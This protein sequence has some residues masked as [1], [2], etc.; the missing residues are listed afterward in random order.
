MSARPLPFV[1]YESSR[2]V[3]NVVVD[4]APN[5][6]TV[7]A[8]THWPGV[9]QPAG[10]GDDLSAQM[11]FRYLDAPPEHPPAEV[12]TNNHFD[13][14]GLVSVHALV[15]PDLSLRHRE[16]LID[17]A[18]AG[19]FGTYRFRA[20]ARA[21]MAIW[22]YAHPERSPIADQL[23][24]LGYPDQCALLYET[25][26]PLLVEMATAPDRY[27]EL[28]NEEDDR[29][30]ASEK[31]IAS[32]RIRV[33]ERHDVDL[34]V[35]VIDEGLP[36]LGGHRFGHDALHELHPMAINNATSCLRLLLVQGRRYRHVDRYETWVQL[37]SRAVR[38]RVDMAPLA[39]RL[40][41]GES[42]PVTWTADPFSTMTP[43][44]ASESES[45]LDAAEVVDA[46]VDHLRSAPP[47]WDPYEVTRG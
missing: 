37:R 13:Q 4:G 15:E 24:G 14:D 41:A 26:L 34:A 45:S 38:P 10:L 43:S 16:L 19:D 9:A 12:V 17:V 42:G 22:V 5:E 6:A 30:T 18:A 33:E 40:T 36:A 20:A 3:P 2:Q 39:E 46:L 27:A 35:V 1:G 7:L 47:A 25:T 31:A 32:G 29:L 44:M 11:A 21:S 8:L 23:A 28:W